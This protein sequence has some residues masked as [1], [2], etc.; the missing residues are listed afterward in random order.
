MYLEILTWQTLNLLTIRVLSF[1][2]YKWEGEM[3]WVIQFHSHPPML[4]LKL[5]FIWDYVAI[6]DRARMR[7]LCTHGYCLWSPSLHL[8]SLRTGALSVVA[9][10]P[11]GRRLVWLLAVQ[12]PQT[13][14]LLRVLLVIITRASFLAIAMFSLLDVQRIVCYL[15]LFIWLQFKHYIL[16]FLF[17]GKKIS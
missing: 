9:A 3:N 2:I 8:W 5:S 7:C 10:R 14:Q 6:H 12:A 16:F 11:W 15:E 4:D 1:L 13:A 17:I